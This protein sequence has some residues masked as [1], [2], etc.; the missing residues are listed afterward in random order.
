[1]SITS[2]NFI[3]L[4]TTSDGEELEYNDSDTWS[5]SNSANFHWNENSVQLPA[6]GYYGV[7]SG[8]HTIA[9]T[10][11]NF[12]GRISVQAS[13]ANNPTEN[14]WFDIKFC[15]SGLDYIEFTDSQVYNPLQNA[16][17]A[18]QGSTGTFAETVIGNFTYL[19]VCISRDYI[20]TVPDEN[21]KRVVGKIAQALI[22]F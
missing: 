17:V 20:A 18:E 15:D 12:V 14:D 13:L 3:F 22:N 5:E 11:N 16:M 21:Q 8:R 19:R 9:I 1:M 10:L 7:T 2:K 6:A 4:R